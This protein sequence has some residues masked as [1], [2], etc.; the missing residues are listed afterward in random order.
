MEM[1]WQQKALALR[2]I[3]APVN[4]F[5][6]HMRDIGD[7]YVHLSYVDRKEGGC[8][9]SGL[10]RGITPEDAINQCWD[11]ATDPKFYLVIGEHKAGRHSVK[12]NG[13]MWQDVEEVL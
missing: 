11:W 13:F 2:A 4:G 3:C 9:S 5:A 8:L 12:W 1:N 6:L 7:W 10:Q